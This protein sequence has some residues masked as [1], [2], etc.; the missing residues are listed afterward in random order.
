MN[1]WNVSR[2]RVDVPDRQV[3]RRVGR[4]GCRYQGG[5]IN[6]GIP[7]IFPNAEDIAYSG[8]ELQEAITGDEAALE[9]ET[10]RAYGAV[11]MG[12][13]NDVSEAQRGST[14]KVAFVAPPKGVVSSGKVV[15]ANEID[16]L[17]RAMSMGTGIMR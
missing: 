10:I 2:R 13:I 12:L 3:D 9:L 4:S 15:E 1:L 6:A 14:P 8:T 17:V 16:L 11:K 5:L 7:T